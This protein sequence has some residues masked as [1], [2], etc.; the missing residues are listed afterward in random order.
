MLFHAFRFIYTVKELDS[1]AKHGQSFKKLFGW[2]MEY[3]YPKYTPSGFVQD[4]EC[5]VFFLDHGSSWLFKF[6]KV[7]YLFNYLLFFYHGIRISCMGTSPVRAGAHVN[8]SESKSTARPSSCFIWYCCTALAREECLQINVFL[9]VRERLFSFPKD[10]AYG[11][12]GCSLFFP[13]EAMEFRKC[14]CLFPS[15]RWQMFYKQGPVRRWICTSFDTERSQQQKIPVMIRHA[16][17]SWLF[18]SAH[19]TPPGAGSNGFK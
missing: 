19:D 17:A 4:S 1:H 14:V 15:F 13:G 2:L 9:V 10:P 8:R 18:N 3:F 12:S 5:Y 16:S 7:F 11:N 6:R